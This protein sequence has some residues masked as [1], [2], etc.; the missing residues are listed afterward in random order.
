MILGFHSFTFG[1][2]Q[3]TASGQNFWSLLF[4][5]TAAL[6]LA[7]VCPHGPPEAVQLPWFVPMGHQRLCSNL[8]AMAFMF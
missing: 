1:K 5:D 3:S 4:V 7:S 2:V 6:T 8:G